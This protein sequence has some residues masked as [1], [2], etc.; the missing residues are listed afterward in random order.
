MTILVGQIIS[1]PGYVQT[2]NQIIFFC[3]VPWDHLNLPYHVS[4]DHF[5]MIIGQNYFI[6]CL[7][8]NKKINYLLLNLLYLLGEILW[9]YWGNIGEILGKYWGNKREI[10]GKYWENIGAIL[11]KYLRNIREILEKY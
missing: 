5:A 2:G 7:H 6:S 9:K 10:L 3:M 11:E 8:L 1:F 4:C